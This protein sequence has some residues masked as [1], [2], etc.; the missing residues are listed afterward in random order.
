MLAMTWMANIVS[1]LYVKD[2][3]SRLKFLFA[4]VEIISLMAA[5]RQS[6]SVIF[7]NFMA[8]GKNWRVSEI[9][10]SRFCHYTLDALVVL[11]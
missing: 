9:L 11:K 4:T 6:V 3:L 7:G 10:T 5:C 1:S 2:G 8:W